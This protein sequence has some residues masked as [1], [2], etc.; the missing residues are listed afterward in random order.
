MLLPIVLSSAPENKPFLSLM[1]NLL[2]DHRSVIE[3]L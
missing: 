3:I 1:K 2:E